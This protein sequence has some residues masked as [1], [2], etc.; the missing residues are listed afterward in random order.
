[1]AVGVDIGGG[2]GASAGGR[3]WRTAGGKGGHTQNA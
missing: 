3:P 1:M 2:E